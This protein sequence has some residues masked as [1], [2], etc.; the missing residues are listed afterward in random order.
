M[1][2]LVT[3]KHISDKNNHIAELSM[4]LLAKIIQNIGNGI[5]KLN[6][7]TLQQIMKALATTIEGK[8]ANM[9]TMALDICMFIYS[10]I[11][12][13]NYLSLMNHTL[14]NEEI[15]NMGKNM[16]MHRVSKN[17]QHVPLANALKQRKTIM[18]QQ[19]NNY[20]GQFEQSCHG[21]NSMQ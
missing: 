15:Q 17:K 9:K 11:G 19:N 10:Q 14:S 16:E 21:Y 20:Q 5:T 1:S 18:N 13:E 12:Q 4:Q 7:N 6:I 8:R 2:Y 3:T